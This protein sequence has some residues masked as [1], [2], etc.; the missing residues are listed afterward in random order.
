MQIITAPSKTENRIFTM[1]QKTMPELSQQHVCWNSLTC[2]STVLQEHSAGTIYWNH[3][4]SFSRFLIVHV[5]SKQFVE[6]NEQRWKSN[7]GPRDATEG[8]SS[9]CQSGSPCFCL[10]EGKAAVHMHT[11]AQPSTLSALNSAA[12]GLRVF[13]GFPCIPWSI[14]TPIKGE[15]RSFRDITHAIPVGWDTATGVCEHE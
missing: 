13:F 2:T 6:F 7:L 4:D 1:S 12:F 15:F 3:I 10:R 14:K 8:K 5:L 9:F 11:V